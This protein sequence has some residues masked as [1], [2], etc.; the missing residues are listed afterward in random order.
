LEDDDSDAIDD[1]LGLS[2]GLITIFRSLVMPDSLNG[3]Y[4]AEDALYD[5]LVSS[6][7]TR[8]RLPI[9]PLLPLGSSVL[10]AY[11]QMARLRC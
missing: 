11:R 9:D 8:G 7:A 10:A 4:T 1:A 2:I 5:R 3:R 6:L